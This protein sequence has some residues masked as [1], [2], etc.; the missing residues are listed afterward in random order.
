MREIS[1]LPDNVICV[2][3]KKREQIRRYC[4]S[5]PLAGSKLAAGE[6]AMDDL[7][8][9]LQD[10]VWSRLFGSSIAQHQLQKDNV[11]PL[12]EFVADFFEVG[13]A[14]EAEAFL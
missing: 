13:D 3:S 10:Q 7:L 11:Q 8:A 5:R 1:R 2:Q 12:A 4:D 9:T 6:V 14:L